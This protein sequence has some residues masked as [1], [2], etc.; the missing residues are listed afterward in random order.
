MHLSCVTN[1]E[2]FQ[3]NKVSASSLQNIFKYLVQK[4]NYC[5]IENSTDFITMEYLS[6]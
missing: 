1:L 3:N 4:V 6:T 2:Y 5:L